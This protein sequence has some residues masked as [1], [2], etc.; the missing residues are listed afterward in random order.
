MKRTPASLA[1]VA[2]LALALFFI[3]LPARA[4]VIPPSRGGT[5]TSSA[6]TVGQVLVGQPNGTYAPQATSSLGVSDD[7]SDNTTSDLAEGS[8]L[9]YTLA[10]VQAALVGG[11]SAIFGSSTTTNAT[12]TN[13]AVTGS[14]SF[15]G[16]TI[17]NVATWFNGLFDTRLATKSTSDLAEGSNLYWTLNRFAAALSG[18]TTDALSEGLT[19]R[20]F[21]D[22]RSRAA[23]SETV[24]GLDYATSTGILSLTS[25]YL[26]PLTSSA[27]DW[28]TAYGWGNHAIQNY[29]DK[30]TDDTGDLTEGSK[31]FFT[32]DR[33]DARID[34]QK[35]QAGGVASLD[36]GGKVPVT[37]LPN[38]IM[39]YQGTW[40][41]TTN[42]PTLADGTGSTGDVYRVS[43]AGTRDLGSG[44]ITFVVGDYAIYNG[45]TWEKADTTDAVSSVN[46]YTG[47]VTLDTGDIAEDGNLYFT[48]A[49]VDARINATSTIATLLSAPNLATVGTIIA[50]VWNGTAIADAYLT[51]TG[52]WLGTLDGYEGAAL[53]ARANHT[54]SQ[55]ASTISDFASTA[56]GLFSS[57]ATGLTYTSG[58]GAFSLTSGYV[59]PLTA[60]TTEWASA[61][62]NRITSLT[63]TGTS[64]AATLTSNVLNIP[65]YQAAGNY[66][67][68][69]TGDVTASGPGSAA[70]TLATVNSN[71][72]SFGSS[73]SIP[74]ITVNGKGLITA[75]SGN[76]VVAPAGTLTGTTLAPGIV[77]SSLTSVSS[78]ITGIV[79]AASGALSAAVAG[80]DYQ[81]PITAGTGL[82][83]SGSTLN[84]MWTTSGS[85][86]YNNNSGNVGIGTTT[87]DATLSVYRHADSSTGSFPT[88]TWATKVLNLTDSSTE[89]GL[90]VA[91]RWATHDSKV[92]EAGSLYN[93]GDGFDS[94]FRITGAG[95][96]G[97]NSA[98]GS[99]FWWDNPNATTMR[100][101]TG[102][103]GPG[104]EQM[105]FG[106]NGNVALGAA[107]TSGAKLN[108]GLDSASDGTNYGRG[109]QIVGGTSGGQQIAFVRG[110][111]NVLSLGYLPGSNAFGF[112]AGNGTDASFTPNLLSLFGGNIGV[113]TSSPTEKL[114]VQGNVQFTG[115][116]GFQK[117]TLYT[118]G[119][120][121]GI[122]N[123]GNGVRYPFK[124]NAGAY[125]DALVIGSTGNVGLG[126]SS[127]DYLLDVES[128]SQASGYTAASFY[129]EA[130]GSG[131]STTSIDITKG[132]G[133]GGRISGFLRQG[134][135]S[136]M[137]LT[138]LNG[139]TPRDVLTLLD[140]GFVGVGTTTPGATFSVAGD[141]LITGITRTAR[142]IVTGIAAAF[143]P[144]VEGEIGIDTTSNQ[145]KFFSGGATRVLSP[146]IE[147]SFSYATSTAWTGTTT[148]P[149]G[150][151]GSAQTWHSIAC[152]TDTGTLNV[153]VYDGTNRMNV[154]G[155]STTVTPVT[156]STNNSFT[157]DEKRYVDIGT[158][159]S[160]PTKVSCT[161]KRT[162]D[163][164]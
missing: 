140:T 20:Y 68:A 32:N 112:G 2:F 53:L 31:L 83:F 18:T 133:Y 95:G 106:D 71:V 13:L 136:G 47:N 128:T 107:G 45:S 44:S 162:T 121:M 77:S 109:I 98:H 59:I 62:L 82:S 138:T 43:V 90:V 16:T 15:L 56:R 46:G 116:A 75:A 72:G 30:D 36:G 9:Y 58:T 57:S 99:I 65:Q 161:T 21:T 1:I 153:S 79:K 119:N 163:A 17:T 24:T 130:N 150:P 157:A 100:F 78:G 29:F 28:N 114:T 14:F 7:L 89:H 155:A 149:L 23:I 113:A 64:G 135:G 11:Y 50:G 120:Q 123:D 146:T 76:A 34:V 51:K 104:A 12:T 158:P 118:D 35:G 132:S 27:A 22:A 141:A 102:A 156:L 96:V 5:G 145:F 87:P 108:I 70:A 137:Y 148:I 61:Y 40:N 142:L 66:L 67:T 80:T 33:A 111:N 134:V 69:L 101:S 4:Q 52:D 55:L 74:T 126:D 60:S 159:A 88:G 152:F 93:N 86:I 124:I 117:Y 122:R 115:G 38:S 73:T 84:S 63:T 85:N 39:E 81:V 25:G 54:G 164:D 110:G 147:S 48:N 26:I 154:V 8:R 19:N 105:L 10:R 127:P 91:N 94:F 151:A 139:G 129:S 42:S 92:F 144:S 3:A 143:T 41:A 103:G 131:V 6:P 49:R 97:I 37:Q 160:S 125:D